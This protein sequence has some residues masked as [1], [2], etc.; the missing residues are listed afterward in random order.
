[1]PV[2]KGLTTINI[3]NSVNQYESN[4]GNLNDD[5]L[6]LVPILD[7]F[8]PVG[9]VYTSTN[10]NF[11]PNKAWGGEWEKIADRFLFSS[12]ARPVGEL[13]G[14]EVVVLTWDQMPPHSHGAGT[15]KSE[16]R[17]RYEKNGYG[18][19]PQEQSGAF[20]VEQGS[21]NAESGGSSGDGRNAT[22]CM[23][24]AN[25]QNGRTDSQG[26]GWGHNNLPPYEVV[27]IWKRMA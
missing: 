17:L 8:Y 13:G 16:G 24:T 15:L 26:D 22:I 25:G 3:F 9:T 14:E 4:K 1:M 18:S 7:V 2:T 6:S 21:G 10:A 11:D 23:N 5:E 27:N 20:W 19:A 12:G